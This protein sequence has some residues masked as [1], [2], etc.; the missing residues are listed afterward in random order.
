MP[1][2]TQLFDT[3]RAGDAAQAQALLDSDSSLAAV[4]D[5][6]GMS[7]LMLALYYGQ[8]Q[9]VDALIAHG[10]PVNIWAASVRG[11]ADRISALLASDAGLVHALSADGW[12]PLHLAAHFGQVAAIERLLDAGAAVD[13]RSTNELRNTPLHAAAAGSPRTSPAAVLL[14]ER[15]A[16]VNATQ[17]GGWTALHATAQNG[18]AGLVA[19]LL[20]RGAEVNPRNDA[21][22]TPLALGEEAGHAD[23]AALLA[24]HGGQA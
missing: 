3:I 17:R 8:L 9:I 16:D 11:D 2:T 18:D 19:F 7:P 13:A 5:N 14:V 12:T 1:A 24:R 21:G 4:T 15:G 23:V 22:Q 10:A 6:D 20:E